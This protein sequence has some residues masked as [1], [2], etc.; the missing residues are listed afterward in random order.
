M[1]DP[2]GSHTIVLIKRIRNVVVAPGVH[3]DVLR[4]S[5]WR[6]HGRLAIRLKCEVRAGIGLYNLRRN[7]G[8]SERSGDVRVAFRTVG[9]PNFKTS[10]GSVGDY[11]RLTFGDSLRK[12]FTGRERPQEEPLP[13]C[14]AQVDVGG[15]YRAVYKFDGGL[16]FGG[17]RSERRFDSAAERRRAWLGGH[18]ENAREQ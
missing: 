12:C 7:C 1:H 13:R 15:L 17:R 6:I 2:V 16:P 5:E 9:S 8:R 11:E 4:L 14:I 3:V 18:N 10:A